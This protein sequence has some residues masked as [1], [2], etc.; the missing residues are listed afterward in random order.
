MLRKSY[1]AVMALVILFLS[2]LPSASQDNPDRSIDAA[3]LIVGPRAPYEKYELDESILKWAAQNLYAPDE[4]FG[5]LMVNIASGVTSFDAHNWHYEKMTLEKIFEQNTKAIGSL[6]KLVYPDASKLKRI[7]VNYEFN[8]SA[9]EKKYCFAWL[10]SET[11]E[12]IKLL[13]NHFE[14]TNLLKKDSSVLYYGYEEVDFHK[15]IAEHLKH[16]D[17]DYWMCLQFGGRW[18]AAGSVWDRC[19]NMAVFAYQRGLYDDAE[20]LLKFAVEKEPLIFYFAADG[21]AYEDLLKTVAALAGKGHEEAIPF[22][23]HIVNFFPFTSYGKQAEDLL[24]GCRQVVQDKKGWM[25]AEP[26]SLTLDQRVKYW[27]ERLPDICGS[28]LSFPGGPEIF[29]YRDDA[30]MPSDR[31]VD[32]GRTAIPALIECLGDT[33]PTRSWYA[34]R[35]FYP[36]RS[37]VRVEG[38]AVRCIEKITDITFYNNSS[39]GAFFSDEEPESREKAIREI[40]EWWDKFKDKPQ[41]DIYIDRLEKAQQSEKV[42]LL[43]KIE[44]IDSGRVDSIAL[45]KKW[46]A[47]NNPY[48]STTYSEELANRGDFT[49]MQ[50][51]RRSL[52]KTLEE[53]GHSFSGFNNIRYLLNHGGAEDYKFLRI[54]AKRDFD[55]GTEPHTESSTWSAIYSAVEGNQ[56]PKSVPLHIDVLSH[57]QQTG[58]RYIDEQHNN[59]QF[60]AADRNMEALIKITGH[61]EGYN[62]VAPS[63]E[64]FAAMDRW[65][66]WWQKEGE[67]DFFSKY[68]EA[69]EVAE[70]EKIFGGPIDAN[71]L[72]PMVSVKDAEF[73]A[74]ISYDVPRDELLKLANSRKIICKVDMFG[75]YLFQW[76]SHNDAIAWFATVKPF[77]PAAQAK[78]NIVKINDNFEVDGA[79][80]GPDG[81]IWVWCGKDDKLS[82]EDI[83]AFVQIE[84]RSLSQKQLLFVPGTSYIFVDSKNRLWLNPYFYRNT[85]LCYDLGTKKWSERKGSV[86]DYEQ[87]EDSNKTVDFWG[88]PYE[89][90]S[91]VVFFPDRHGIHVFDSRN[92]GWSYQPLYEK[93]IKEKVYYAHNITGIFGQPFF[94]E[95]AAG[96]IYV[97]TSWGS[98][99]W[100]GTLGYWIFDGVKWTNNVSEYHL[101]SV[102][103]LAGGDV[104]ILDEE[105]KL[106]LYRGEKMIP[107]EE[108]RKILF[109]N[110]YF[111]NMYN[112]NGDNNRTQYL[113]LKGVVNYDTLFGFDAVGYVVTPEGKLKELGEGAGDFFKGMSFLEDNKGWLWTYNKNIII[114][115]SADGKEFKPLERT[116]NLN[117]VSLLA[118]GK[119]GNI[120]L[121][122]GRNIWKLDPHAEYASQNELSFSALPAMRVEIQDIACPDTAGRVWCTFK[123]RGAFASVFDGK[124]WNVFKDSEDRYNGSIQ[125]FIEAFPGRKGDMIFLDWHHRYCLF[126]AEGWVREP[127]FQE[128][129]MK[130]NER[131]KKVLEYPT[132]P[133]FSQGFYITS[134]KKGRL[135]WAHWEHGWGVVIDKDTSI[136]G[137]KS[138]VSIKPAPGYPLYGIIPLDN[139]K[140][141][142]IMKEKGDIVVVAAEGNAI[143]EEMK[144]EIFV[145]HDICGEFFYDKEGLIWVKGEKESR[146]FNA[147][148]DIVD[149]VPGKALMEDSKG[150]IW[151]QVSQ[152][153]ASAIVRRDS[154]GKT[155]V[156]KLSDNAFVSIAEGIDGA[157]WIL[158]M[159]GL[160]KIA[161]EKDAITTM[162]R[163]Y[164]PVSS[165]DRIWCDKEGRVWQVHNKQLIRYA[166]D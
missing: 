93:N 125:G 112:R 75:K 163:Y 53:G 60:G 45:L 101:G 91:G 89:S 24:K 4:R 35:D 56:L 8:S 144:P 55:A 160:E 37:I 140:D 28:Q 128:L 152:W 31:I 73:G 62:Q 20:S 68:P 147:D 165:W 164:M 122:V 145:N 30:K 48:F 113:S 22:F 107:E 118:S 29:S 120:Y 1:K 3:K 129:A 135:W 67:A 26:E 34:Q 161:V 85:L 87:L 153:N 11:D 14:I 111:Q 72:S 43:R 84:I 17:F 61:N 94:A 79:S 39:T 155:L 150:S 10:T 13:G 33:R 9:G 36:V 25:T 121:T 117:N 64:R 115:M 151:Y 100:T 6:A 154:G 98:C 58:V 138:N 143:I 16:N 104:V 102:L 46:T 76:N 38:V 109:P 27:V 59:V 80:A 92:G 162:E 106:W 149:S 12:N 132:P 139:G 146:V 83:K 96:N 123:A 148:G 41:I 127:S 18:S 158:T 23:E 40:K 47:E 66:E 166:T 142:L 119:D 65:L 130:H 7:K 88:A 133:S 69:R 141:V 99:G 134:D 110:L 74:V 116:R 2:T 131:V 15:E 156:R 71:K 108:A 103:P 50:A 54:V 21:Y 78:Q 81:K 42:E 57:R 95:D 157:Y 90:K 82:I 44:E 105:Y 124:N 49:Y 126:D 52:K 51:L 137:M 97:W 136:D 5:K 70:L 114:G 159:E 77:K 32:L 63:E 86:P 19:F